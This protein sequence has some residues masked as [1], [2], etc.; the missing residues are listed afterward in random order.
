MTRGAHRFQTRLAKTGKNTTGIVVP[1]LVIAELGAGARPALVVKINAYT[2]RSTVGVMGGQSM[3]PFSAQH[4]DASGIQGGDPIE[5]ELRLDREPRTVE[6]PDD[7]AQALASKPRLRAAF[8]QQAPSRRK[9]DIDNVL[10][11]KAAETRAR[12]I[13]AIVA[14]LD[15]K[16][17][18]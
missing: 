4:R 13:A 15:A 11:A 5:V 7:L 2:Y 1:P 6:L 14:R 3:L 12:R 17:K 8:D 10:G 16:P 18:P 9:A